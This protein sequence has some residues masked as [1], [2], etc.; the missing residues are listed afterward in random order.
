MSLDVK[1][2]ELQ[3]TSRNIEDSAKRYLSKQDPQSTRVAR[4]QL[5]R[6]RN[7]TTQ[8]RSLEAQRSLLLTAQ[9]NV[10]IINSFES[11]RDAI[12]PATEEMAKLPALQQE[13]QDLLDLTMETSSMINEMIASMEIASST[14]DEGLDDEIEALRLEIG[15]AEKAGHE[16]EREREGVEYDSPSQGPGGEKVAGASTSKGVK[17]HTQG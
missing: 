4:V 9:T 15:Q 12:K 6:R 1:I 3:E 7:I 14:V 11:T 5:S 13:M 16:A 2:R 10:E 17:L 8:I